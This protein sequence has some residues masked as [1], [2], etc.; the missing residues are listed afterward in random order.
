MKLIDKA[1]FSV[2]L[3]FSA[4]L[5]F[6]GSCTRIAG[7]V[8]SEFAVIGKD[9]WDP[10]MKLDFSPWPFDSVSLPDS[11]YD[12]T[13]CVRHSAR[14]PLAPLHLVVAQEWEDGRTEYDTI[15]MPLT[16]PANTPSGRGSYGVYE[17]RDTI[18]SAIRLESD[19]RVTLTSL[20]PAS[21]TKGITDIGLVLSQ[22]GISR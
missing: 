6:C 5:L 15:R 3:A 1:I 2:A 17:T 11:R 13:L 14:K 4:L 8:W 20:S 19:Y 22:S 9:G 18:A 10:V 21:Q 16:P 7:V 12:L